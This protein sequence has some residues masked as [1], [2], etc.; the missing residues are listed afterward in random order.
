MDI[1]RTGNTLNRLHLQTILHQLSPAERLI[2]TLYYH[3]ENTHKE[4][5]TIL[6]LSESRVKQIHSSVLDRLN[7]RLSHFGARG[8][9]TMGQGLGY[10]VQYS[11]LSQIKS[12][13]G[14]QK[15]H[16]EIFDRFKEMLELRDYIKIVN[17]SFVVSSKGNGIPQQNFM[18][19]F[20]IQKLV[21]K[22]L[23]RTHNAFGES[24]NYKFQGAITNCY[25]KSLDTCCYF[26]TEVF[27]CTN[28]MW[29]M[30]GNTQ[31]SQKHAMKTWEDFNSTVWKL[32]SELDN[33]YSNVVAGFEGLKEHDF[34]S[35]RE[36]NDFVLQ[37]SQRGLLSSADIPK[38][39]KHWNE[40]EHAEFKD[41]NAYSLFNAYT[42]Y[43]RDSNQLVLP[44]KTMG[45]RALIMEFKQPI[46]INRPIK[47][48]ALTHK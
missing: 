46:R 17:P 43:W 19:R 9:K 47:S 24:P 45:L 1:A 13:I 38:V 27:V 15:Q 21:P 2:I 48:V 32:S 33:I 29:W 8:Q 20:E 44:G 34:S 39:L 35:Q 28:G 3:E 31:T 37:S 10:E 30:T 4:I 5:G 40:P 25:G 14:S 11:Q 22:K 7:Q 18:A 36:V 12:S 41:R 6:D 16:S 23:G 42:S 26:G